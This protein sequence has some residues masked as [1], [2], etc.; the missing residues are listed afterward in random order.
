MKEFP[1]LFGPGDALMGVVTSPADGPSVPVACVL[2]N[3]GAT[4]RAG[5]RRINVK[6][7]R[8][9]A[10]LGFTSIRFD[11]S[12]LGDSAPPVDPKGFM[13]QSALD[14]Q[15]A[16][17]TVE[18]VLGIRR[19][20]VIGFC[21]GAVNGLAVAQLDPRVIGLLMF[22]G[23]SFPTGRVLKE[24]NLRRLLALPFNP[25]VR[26]KTM[27]W[28]RRKVNAQAPDIFSYEAADAGMERYREAVTRLLE[29]GTAVL[30]LYSGTLQ[31][32]DRGRDQLS[33]LGDAQLLQRID[34]RF[35]A[36]IDHTLTTVAS[37]RI[38]L[39]LLGDWA[40]ALAAPGPAAGGDPGASTAQRAANM[41]PLVRQHRSAPD[42]AD[43]PAAMSMSGAPLRSG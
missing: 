7:A 33:L 22:D 16:M 11:L 30:A 36:D 28:L 6:I 13:A 20:I 14:L 43:A 40:V 3:M 24:R 21:S 32:H 38:F 15:A 8:Q 1:I 26:E 23:F 25:A 19:F 2:Y 31:A 37:Q 10:R 5:P 17:N 29:R 4:Y 18:T 34:Y 35:V 42:A 9:M 27:R 41:P 39:Q 12:G